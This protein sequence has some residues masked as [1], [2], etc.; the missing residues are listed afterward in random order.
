LQSLIFFSLLVVISVERKH[1]EDFAIVLGRTDGRGIAVHGPEAIIARPHGYVPISIDELPV[2]RASGAH[3]TSTPVSQEKIRF[4]TVH[5][6]DRNLSRLIITCG[7][8]GVD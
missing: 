2:R 4:S 3:H 6:M 8:D 7:S 1:P 5:S